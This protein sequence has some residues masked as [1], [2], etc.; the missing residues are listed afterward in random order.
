MVNWIPLGIAVVAVLAVIAILFSASSKKA[1]GRAVGTGTESDKKRDS[2]I[3][4]DAT[5]KLKQDP[6]HAASLFAL[7]DCYYRHHDFQ[8]AYPLYNTLVDIAKLHP[9]INEFT[10][11]IRLGICAVK[12]EKIQESFKGLALAFQLKPDDFEAC[13]YLGYACYQNNDFA[14]AIPCLKKA[15][16]IK[17]DSSSVFGPLGKALYKSGKF[18]ESLK[19]LRRTIDE[20]PEDKETLFE[21]A[22]AMYESGFGDKAVK[23]FMHLRPD[24]VFG[25]KSCLAVGKMHFN[26]KQY[27]KAFQDFEIGLKI[28]DMPQNIMVELN[29]NMAQTCFAINKMGLGLECLKQI[30]I[31]APNY[32]DVQALISR[33]Q[34][35]NQNSNLK[36]YIMSGTSDF[37]AL[38][39]KVVAS[40]YSNSFVKVQDISIIPEGADILCAI[41]SSKWED[42]ELFRFYRTTGVV[43]EL[44]VRDFHAK[45]RDSKADKGLC[46]AAGTFSE[47]AH[48]YTEG[49]PIDLIEKDTLVKVLKKIDRLH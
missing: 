1:T 25:P 3:I 35:L 27:E 28:Q 2:K 40:Y 42:T 43:G 34:E 17:P 22:D 12:L 30:Q 47:G 36:I 29:Y 8:K 26:A 48:K 18:K 16:V 5:R 21:I 49:R 39:S 23:I 7:S 14:R 45:I 37:V 15:L 19:F 32:K 46:F 10:V 41:E 4:R 24:P 20:H 31:V 38:C 9:E 13:Y 44:F 6:H 11:A 33:Y